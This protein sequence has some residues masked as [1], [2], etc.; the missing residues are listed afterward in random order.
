[1]R[2]TF[3]ATTT[4]AITD[5]SVPCYYTSSGSVSPGHLTARSAAPSRHRVNG[6]VGCQL[7]SHILACLRSPG[8]S[9]R[10]GPTARVCSP[11][12]ARCRACPG[13]QRF[14][15]NAVTAARHRRGHAPQ[16]VHRQRREMIRLYGLRMSNYCS[17]VK[18][19]RSRRALSWKSKR[20]ARRP[21][22]LAR[23]PMDRM[24]SIKVSAQKW[25]DPWLHAKFRQ[26]RAT[27][28]SALAAAVQAI[29][30][31]VD[32]HTPAG[33]TDPAGTAGR[34]GIAAPA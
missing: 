14:V 10:R 31:H 8:G 2:R 29:G 25:P 18:A 17:L 26:C 7:C 1:V 6:R 5:D 27:P 30:V 15:R 32:R 13:G 9:Q 16:S 11:P 22:N 21:T 28:A 4:F 33:N 3:V 12:H 19:L 34:A 24:P 23:S 20:P